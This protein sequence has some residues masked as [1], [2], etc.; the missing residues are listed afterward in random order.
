MSQM[1]DLGGPVAAF[2]REHCVV[3]TEGCVPIAVLHT[4]YGQE[5]AKEQR[6]PT[7]KNVFSSEVVAAFPTVRSARRRV[8]E[9]GAQVHCFLGLR[10]REPERPEPY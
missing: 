2:V 3:D 7:A 9:G 5:E 8:G 1:R 6:F 10:L 4:L